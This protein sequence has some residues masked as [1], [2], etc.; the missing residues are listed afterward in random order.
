MEIEPILLR[1]FPKHAI[2]ACMGCGEADSAGDKAIRLSIEFT[3]CYLS[4]C[5]QHEGE[6]LEALLK[7]Y[8]RR[9]GK[10]SKE[11]YLGPLEKPSEQELAEEEEELEFWLGESE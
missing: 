5:P 11:G 8:L 9:K 7:N 6:L 2:G 4:L 3:D 1:R 10:N